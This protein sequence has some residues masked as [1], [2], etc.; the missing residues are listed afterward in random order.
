MCKEKKSHIEKC[1]HAL[2]KMVDGFNALNQPLTGKISDVVLITDVVDLVPDFDDDGNLTCF[3]KLVFKRND[4][5]PFFFNVLFR[6]SYI[7]PTLID[8]YTIVY[9]II[10]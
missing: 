8:G 1:F 3:G 10:D 6:T 9:T 7:V 2:N 5:V 4:Y